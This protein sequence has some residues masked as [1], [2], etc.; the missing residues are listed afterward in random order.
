MAVV[1]CGVDHV[2]GRLVA[3]KVLHPHLLMKEEARVRFAREA[4]VI[5]RL[6]HPGIVEVYD[7]PGA[8]SDRSFIVTE[9]VDGESLDTF[10]KRGKWLPPEVAALV[11]S[12]VGDALAHAHERGVIHRDVKPE[13]LMVRGDGVM[14]LMDFGIAHVIDM[15]HLTMTG[16][17]LGS[18]AHMSPEQIDGRALD[19]RTDVFSLGTLFYLLATGE[20]PFKADTPTALLRLIAEARFPDPRSIRSGFPDDLLAILLKMMAKEPDDRYATARES[21]DALLAITGSLG[22]GPPSVELP[23]LFADRNAYCEEALR[24]VAASRLARAREHIRLGQQALA[25]REAG[26]ALACIPDDPQAIEVL[27]QARR[28]VRRRSFSR[29]SLAILLASLG[30]IGTIGLG[31][32]LWPSGMPI[33]EPVPSG[34]VAAAVETREEPGA[35]AVPALRRPLAQ[36]PSPD[37]PPD[38]VRTRERQAPRSADLPTGGKSPS[39]PVAA[40]LPVTIQAH[41]PAVQIEVDGRAVGEGKVEGLMLPPGRHVV[42]LSHPSC[43]VCRDVRQVFVLD[44]A[45]PMKGPLRL[46]IGYQDATLVVPAIAGGQVFVNDEERSR[47]PST[48]PLKFPMTTPGPISVKVRIEADG[49]EL[50]T[51]RANLSAGRTTT[52]GAD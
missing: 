49:Q 26:A 47:G 43:D 19:A 33:D 39:R 13:N 30:L 48:Q 52:I 25:M 40:L 31:V 41:P 51:L 18:P 21:T 22:F 28:S 50:R 2:L 7:F 14:K 38:V 35:K 11:T 32:A 16:A 20:Y 23:R 45:M 10:I 12:A 37:A 42:H 44:S 46:S 9:F 1:Y 4:Q 27:K 6:K 24:R 36:D 17:I 34:A 3:I 5:A 8:D 29:W 15:E